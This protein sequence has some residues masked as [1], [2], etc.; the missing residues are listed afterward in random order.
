MVTRRRLLA[1]L[2]ALALVGP[3]CLGDPPPPFRDSPEPTVLD[4]VDLLNLHREPHTVSVVVVDAG[5]VVHWS[6]H[7][8][9]GYVDGSA[10]GGSLTCDW[11]RDV[12]LA[13]NARLDDG[14]WETFDLATVESDCVALSLEVDGDG[15]LAFWYT[16]S[17]DHALCPSERDD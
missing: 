5:E 8:M 17:C 4:A 10:D 12:T 9:R 6:H 7:E 3:G 14:A 13:V 1:T 2:P 11:P 15:D 16:S